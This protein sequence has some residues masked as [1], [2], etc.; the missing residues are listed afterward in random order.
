[1]TSTLPAVA[2]RACGRPSHGVTAVGLPPLGSSRDRAHVSQECD[3]WP[4]I[5]SRWP[6]G[7]VQ[8]AMIGAMHE[9]PDHLLT[10]W[11]S[12][13]FDYTSAYSSSYTVVYT[14]RQEVS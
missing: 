6:E 13:T 14:K 1:M 12:A 8:R 3:H 4:Q 11:S 7:Q 9:P 10:D 5:Q 2:A